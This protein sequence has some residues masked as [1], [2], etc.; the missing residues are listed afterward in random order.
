MRRL[1]WT[2]LYGIPL[3]EYMKLAAGHIHVHWRSCRSK[4][5]QIQTVTKDELALC[6][7]AQATGQGLIVVI[8]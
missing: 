7:P 1:S 5:L 8:Q 6:E 2:R 3:Y 4:K